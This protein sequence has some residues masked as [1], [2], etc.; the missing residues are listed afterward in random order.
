MRVW[1]SAAS[2]AE[3]EEKQEQMAITIAERFK[4]GNAVYLK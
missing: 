4:G 1:I 2:R 3:D